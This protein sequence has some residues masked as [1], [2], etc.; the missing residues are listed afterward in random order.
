MVANNKI[1]ITPRINNDG[2]VDLTI[3][4]DT[5]DFQG[6][7]A[8]IKTNRSIITRVQMGIGEVLVLGGLTSSKV[9][10]EITKTPILSDIPIIKNLFQGK[11]KTK[12]TANLYMFLRVSVIKPQTEG[13]ADDYTQLKLDYAKRQIL[14]ADTYVKDKDPI[15]RWFFKPKN[16]SIS[17]TIQNIN[18]ARFAPIDNFAENKKCPP[19]T[20]IIN[21]PFYR[22]EGTIKHEQ[23]HRA[24]KRNQMVQ[25][26][27][28]SLQP[29]SLKKRKPIID[30]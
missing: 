30:S 8:S 5:G 18:N 6:T 2:I 24:K 29:L 15:Q 13:R 19:L 10:D 22:P 25:N 27:A 20:D 23:H 11:S 4:I 7:S 16:H 26:E 3:A 21:D 17:E 1:T 12:T 28:N 9:V 14:N